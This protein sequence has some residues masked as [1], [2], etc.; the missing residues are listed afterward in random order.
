MIYSFILLAG[1]AFFSCEHEH[2]ASGYFRDLA[3]P[4]FP[5]NLA[6]P[7]A[8][9]VL[10]HS[11]AE[12]SGLEYYKQG[13]LACIQDEKGHLFL[14]D[15]T[16]RQVVR[17]IRFAGKGDF[18]SVAIS[19]EQAYMLESNG[20]LHSFRISEKDEV[21]SEIIKTPFT[22]KNNLEG[23]C[24]DASDSSL[25]MLC[26]YE[27]GI[28]HMMHGRAVYRFDL[29]SC[30]LDKKPFIHITSEEFR[31][32]LREFNLEEINHMPF[33]P[34]GIAISPVDGNYFIIASVGEILIVLNHDKEIVKMVPL[35]RE[36]F[37][38]PEGIC[39]SPEG[40]LFISSEGR[41]AEGYILKF[42][43]LPFD[44]AD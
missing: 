36:I 29:K 33:K 41:G 15:T 2:H 35:P 34:S 42:R 24:F 18:E 39:F 31:K 5:Y 28:N 32:K 25:L 27:A 3:G 17:E 13:I 12:I 37:A 43:K 38:Q 16:A 30:N 20:I 8:R 10:D 9:Y 11:L 26:K 44:N 6:S 40:D 19:G 4:R 14:F 23:M 1:F 21:N 22:V 7:S